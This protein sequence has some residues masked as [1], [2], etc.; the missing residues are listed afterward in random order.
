M[1]QI[2][3]GDANTR[4]FH[5]SVKIRR[6]RNKI[7]RNTIKGCIFDQCGIKQAMVEFY[8]SLIGTD[9]HKRSYAPLEVTKAGSVVNEEEANGLCMSIIDRKLR[10]HYRPQ[11]M[12]C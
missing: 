4:F 8:K 9:E 12:T 3:L 7:T 11:G 1:C 10:V 5:N 6:A 2:N